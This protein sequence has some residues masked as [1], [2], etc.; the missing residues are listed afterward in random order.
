MLSAVDLKN[1]LTNQDPD[2]AV[3]EALSPAWSIYLTT[4]LVVVVTNM[5]PT[6]AAVEF[7]S[8]AWS[9][10]VARSRYGRRNVGLREWLKNR[11]AVAATPICV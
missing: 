9:A 2:T 7:I 6:A 4:H 5:D 10:A 1:L 3:S 11:A 8:P